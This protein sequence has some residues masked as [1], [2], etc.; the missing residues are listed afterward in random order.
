MS[1]SVG[2]ERE[3]ITR[4]LIY[5][6]L[7]PRDG[8]QG[9]QPRM[10]RAQVAREDVRGGGGL[11][12]HTCKMVQSLDANALQAVYQ[13]VTGLALSSE[14]RECAW[15]THRGKETKGE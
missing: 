7:W 2:S 14:T 4:W 8:P 15:C 13:V 10:L 9:A 1:V 6:G 11:V 5:A 3:R 12:C